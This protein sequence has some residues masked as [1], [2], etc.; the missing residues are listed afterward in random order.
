M[1]NRPAPR[2]APQNKLAEDI[3]AG[4][5]AVFGQHP[6]FRAVHAKGAMCR[7]SFVPSPAAPRLTRAAHAARP[8]TPVLVRFSDFAGVP[9][10]P[11]N[12]L[13]G[14]GPRGMAIRFNLA[15][16]EHTDIVAH[17]YN[18][19]PV[20]TGEEF[21]EFVR[22]LA[23]SG[24]DAPK[25][26]PIENFLASHP[27][28]LEFATTPKPIP[29]SFT[30]EAF[31]GVSAVKF[32]SSDGASRMCRYQLRPEQGTD[33]LSADDAA[34]KSPNF[35]FEELS[36]RLAS[37][38]VKFRIDLEIAEPGDEMADAS[39]HWP[40]NRIVMEFGTLTLSEM[41]DDSQPELRKVIFDPIPRIIGLEP[42]ADPL[43]QLRADIYLM[44]GRRRRA[45]GGA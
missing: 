32:I 25:P 40:E 24:P 19:F 17:S 22:A 14:A 20:R 1:S 37:G 12:D 42:S 33:Y 44:S 36:A 6:G 45:A 15:E 16:H 7:G 30:R 13:Q 2:P 23:A 26:T 4:L 41:A 38:P 29:T 28:A 21:L 35:L 27:A 3:L 31:F 11:D 5:D 18:G 43:W 39:H 34:Q 8:S 10:I 9:T